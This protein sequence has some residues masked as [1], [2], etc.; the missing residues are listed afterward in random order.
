MSRGS[1]EQVKDKDA[2]LREKVEQLRVVGHV[3]FWNTLNNEKHEN[4]SEQKVEQ[5]VRLAAGTVTIQSENNRAE[6]EVNENLQKLCC[7]TK[8]SYPANN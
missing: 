2:A 5:T 1:V 7:T 6:T 3:P 8:I 4:F